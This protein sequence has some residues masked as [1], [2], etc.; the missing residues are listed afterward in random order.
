MNRKKKSRVKERED[1][2]KHKRSELDDIL[3]ETQKEEKALIKESEK[4]EKKIEE[5][6][7]KAYKRIRSNVKNGLAVVQVERGASGG[8]FFNLFGQRIY[9]GAF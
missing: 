6:L 3:S 9:I 5:R 7:I 8:A 1:H 2:L 4:Y